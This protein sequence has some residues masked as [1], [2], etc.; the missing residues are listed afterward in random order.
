MTVVGTVQSLWRYP[1][2]SMRGES[3]PEAFLGFAGV[4]GDRVYAFR[5][6]AASPGFPYLTAREYEPLLVF[7]ASFRH[8]DR[9]AHPPNLPDAEALPPGATPI[10]PEPDEFAA[11][12][13]VPSGEV[14]A[15]DDPRL[16]EMLGGVEDARGRITLHR[17][18]RAMTDCRPISL[19]S[20]QTAQQLAEEVGA[21]IDK[22]RFRA[23]VYL[24][25]GAGGGFREGDFIGRQ[26]C[27][28][29]KAIVSVTDRDPR[30]KMITLDPDSA[31][32][33]PD[34]LRT[35]NRLHD[36]KAG[37]YGAVLVEGV[38]RPGDSVTIRG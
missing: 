27:I 15:I 36:N 9:L 2:K 7:K 38:V 11:T 12:V 21:E 4:Y 13:E 18:D 24:D 35:V 19:F 31:V 5:S 14:M 16:L 23:N 25:L 28:G 10:Y 17:S 37:V 33:N 6:S 29:D 32:Q 3:L 8:A 34:V 20:I 22:R 26:L 1:V 30:C